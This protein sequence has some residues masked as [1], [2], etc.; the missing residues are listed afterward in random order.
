MTHQQAGMQGAIILHNYG[1]TSGLSQGLCG[2]LCNPI[3]FLN[4]AFALESALSQ[5]ILK[6]LSRLPQ[7]QNANQVNKSDWGFVPSASAFQ[8]GYSCSSICPSCAARVKVSKPACLSALFSGS[9]FRRWLC[10][11]RF[12]G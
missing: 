10:R 12:Q 3:H 11:L 1:E 6:P 8:P 4:V 2:F 5:G 9:C 7:P